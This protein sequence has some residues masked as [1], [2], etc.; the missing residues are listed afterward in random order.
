MSYKVQTIA[1][2]RTVKA[3]RGQSL[4][5]DLG[6]TFTGTLTAWMKRKATDSTFRSFTVVDGRYLFLPKEKAQDLSATD[7]VEGKWYFDVRHLAEGQTDPNLEEMIFTGAINF[8]NHITD[9][10]GTETATVAETES[11]MIALSNTSS[12][13]GSVGQVVKAKE[14]I[15]EIKE[16]RTIKAMRAESLT[17]D[18]RKAYP[19]H[20]LEAW[21]KKDYNST[22]YRS[23]SI[24]DQR[25]LFLSK[26]KTEDYYNIETGKLIEKIAGKWYF[27]V[28]A[29]PNEATNVDDESIIV[30]GVIY[31]ENSVTDSNA[32]ELVYSE[33]PFANDFIDLNDTPAEYLAED[34][35]KALVINSTST[36]VEFKTIIEDLHYIHDQGM[37]NVVWAVNHNLNKYPS[38]A[39][40]DTANTVVMG[41]I[42]YIDLNNLTI[43]FNASFS[44]EAYIN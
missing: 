10:N 11:G 6:E 42:E 19:N 16:V 28:R 17:I 24:V 9:S 27:D 33:R 30:K 18:L 37:P 23:F 34:A 43:T 3:L 7:I 26:S 1:N 5:I 12:V 13:Y 2:L 8:S 40:V 32:Q 35:G 36:E 21:M 22:M 41:Q 25:Y 4:T 14:L 29:I 20:K 15:T 39:A 44:G 31:F 38:A